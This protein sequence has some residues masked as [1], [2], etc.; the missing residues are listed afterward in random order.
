MPLI[1]IL[2]AITNVKTINQFNMLGSFI[3]FIPL[4]VLVFLFLG[5]LP[6][7]PQPITCKRAFRFNNYTIATNNTKSLCVPSPRDHLKTSFY[8]HNGLLFLATI[9][10]AK[11]KAYS[12]KIVQAFKMT[13]TPYTAIVLTLGCLASRLYR[14]ELK[15][16]NK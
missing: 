5:D 7:K 11:A 3:L 15:N 13:H 4:N 8:C 9:P 2:T 16:I 1:M 12:F 14:V 10:V 6:H